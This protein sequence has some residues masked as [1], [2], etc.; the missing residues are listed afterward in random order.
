[1]RPVFSKSNRQASPSLAPKVQELTL[2]PF[3]TSI[4]LADHSKKRQNKHDDFLT[5]GNI[6][7]L[8]GI[9]LD[10]ELTAFFLPKPSSRILRS[11]RCVQ[12]VNYSDAE[13][14]FKKLC[15]SRMLKLDRSAID[16]L[17][18]ATIFYLK[19]CIEGAKQL[20]C[21]QTPLNTVCT[22]APKDMLD[23]HTSKRRKL[24]DSNRLTRSNLVATLIGTWEQSVVAKYL[25]MF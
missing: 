7:S 9:H 14:Y 4:H 2:Q 11:L 25:M 24:N 10:D 21:R 6:L 8:A 5:G 19:D 23:L 20:T 13:R 17:E 12:L 16:L 22:S 15:S 3:Q 18:S 1:M